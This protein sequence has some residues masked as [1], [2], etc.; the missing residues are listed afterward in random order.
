MA[1]Q[2]KLFADDP[3]DSTGVLHN[4]QDVPGLSYLAGLL[5]P[6]QQA[7]VLAQ[8]DTRPWPS[9]IKRRIEAIKAPKAKPNAPA[10]EAP[11]RHTF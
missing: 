8:V 10:P 4:Y 3:R 1:K 11:K 5:S 9:D 6:K 7:L 2:R